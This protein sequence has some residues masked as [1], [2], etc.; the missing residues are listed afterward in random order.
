M[1]RYLH[2]VA[3]ISLRL[4]GLLPRPLLVVAYGSVFVLWLALVAST[5][6]LWQE[7]QIVIEQH[8]V[9]LAGTYI[10]A[11][12]PAGTSASLQAVVASG[13]ALT[14]DNAPDAVTHPKTGRVVAAW[15][16]TSFDAVQAWASF[17]ANK[18]VLD[19]VSPF[20][21]TARSD[22]TLVPDDGARD[23][24]LIKAAHAANVLVLPTIHNVD[25]A[26]AV[27]DVINDADRRAK[28]IK[29]ILTEIRTYEYD[30]IDIDYEALPASSRDNFSAFIEEL[31]GA[32]HAENKL[33]TI[34]VHAKDVDLNGLGAFQDWKRLGAACDRVR[35]MTYD[36]HWRGSGPGPI[37]PVSW[38]TSVTQYAR[39]VMPAQKI[40]LGIPF[41]GYNWG[42]NGEAM[43]QTWTEIR[44]LIEQHQPDVHVATRDGNGAVE[45]SWFVYRSGGKLRTVWFNDRRSID[46]K[47]ALVEQQDM[48]GIAIWRLGSEDPENWQ[49]LRNRLGNH[50]LVTQ[51]VF[52]SYLPN[53]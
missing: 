36:D 44:A 43:P 45:E 32:L 33:L 31:A 42:E 49:V 17:E 34:A 19:E 50:P 1:L 39:S 6:Q 14:S 40:E 37:A 5:I 48:A 13:R 28:H 11:A 23:R 10:D 27:F 25:D 2:L 18:D 15:L 4:I 9:G 47:L 8:H 51:R 21:Y 26:T 38:V 30:G 20:W 35:V 12:P 46:A 41:Y 53:H 22:G 29:A 3:Q 7:R 24:E 52:N 16:P